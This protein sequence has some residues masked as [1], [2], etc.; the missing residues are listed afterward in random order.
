MTNRDM[1]SLI[2]PHIEKWFRKGEK[3]KSFIE[4][5]LLEIGCV[6]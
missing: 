3:I 5:N 1:L 6:L 2:D 4:S